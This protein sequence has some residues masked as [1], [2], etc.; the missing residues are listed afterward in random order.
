[1]NYNKTRKIHEDNSLQPPPPLFLK[2]INIIV[3]LWWQSEA[4]GA[5]LIISKSAALMPHTLQK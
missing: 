5:D 1:M 3:D 4:D 2:N